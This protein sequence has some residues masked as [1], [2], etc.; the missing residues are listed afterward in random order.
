MT[1]L[2]TK[3]NGFIIDTLNPMAPV[4]RS[5]VQKAQQLDDRCFG[6]V[7]AMIADYRET[8]A[9]D[10]SAY[11]G[12]WSTFGGAIATCIWECTADQRT[13]F[14][15]W[16][17]EVEGKIAQFD[18]LG[19]ML[20][21]VDKAFTTAQFAA[22]VLVVVWV[23]AS[24]LW[25]TFSNHVADPYEGSDFAA[26]VRLHQQE[27]EQHQALSQAVDGAIAEFQSIDQFPV[28]E[29]ERQEFEPLAVFATAFAETVLSVKEQ[30][31]PVMVLA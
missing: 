29:S 30:P 10:Y 20:S 4:L 12:E 16:A 11:I 31:Q 6:P 21:T 1:I 22:D 25:V 23:I 13:E 8:V 5:T 18:W 9:A 28:Q 27:M 7:N 15:A 2:S 26:Q 24:F 17:E 19:F 3:N 14:L